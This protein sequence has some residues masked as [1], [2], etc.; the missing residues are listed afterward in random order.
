MWVYQIVALEVVLS[1]HKAMDIHHTDLWNQTT[2]QG[3]GDIG[4][5]PVIWFEYNSS[6]IFVVK[7]AHNERYIC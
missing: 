4:R 7:L 3:N 2:C 1:I 5:Q 6:V